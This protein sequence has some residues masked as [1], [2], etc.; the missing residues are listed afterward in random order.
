MRD[1]IAVAGD[2]LGHIWDNWGDG[3]PGPQQTRKILEHLPNFVRTV[4]K[5]GSEK[6]Y[7]YLDKLCKWIKD[8]DHDPGVVNDCIKGIPIYNSISPI[9][10]LPNTLYRGMRLPDDLRNRIIRANDIRY[11]LRNPACSWS[12]VKSAAI[13]FGRIVL[14]VNGKK[15]PRYANVFLWPT[16]NTEFVEILHLRRHAEEY[17]WAVLLKKEMPVDHVEI[18]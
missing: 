2:A 15:L 6:V 10:P 14:S 3:D 18:L 7:F 4:E 12:E 11:G 16:K 13:Q 5:F 17:E 8:N 1:T 9:P